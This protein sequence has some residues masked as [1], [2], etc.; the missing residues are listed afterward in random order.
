MNRKILLIGAAV[1]AVVVIIIYVVSR[2]PGEL[3]LTGIVT[4]ND[5][6]VSPQVSGQVSRLL[7]EEGDSVAQDQL[8]A[9]LSPAELEADQTY[10]AHSAQ[11]MASQVRQSE[12]DLRFQEAQASEQVREAVAMLAAAIAQAAQDSA[13]MIN[14]RRVY[15][16]YGP[17]LEAGAVSTQQVDSARTGYTVAQARSEASSRQVEAQRAAVALARANEDQVAGKRSALGAARQTQA[18]AAAQSRKADVRLA[19]TEVHAPIAGLVDVRAVRAGEYVA[20][21][22]PI[23]TLVNPDSLWVRA[24]VEETYIDRVRIGDRLTVRLPSGVERP[25][26][27]FFRGVDADF[28]TQRDVSRTKRDIKTF[29]IRLRVDNRDRRLAVGMTAYVLLPLRD[30]SR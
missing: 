6:I 5:V 9:V 1:V 13:T 24:D 10:F 28:A 15:E 7:V 23:V 25:G 18:A 22:Q 11:A 3:V 19:Y 12:A 26:T 16:R 14:A 2:G 20:A 27:V 17:L 29:E 30:G 4:T 21:G 8:L